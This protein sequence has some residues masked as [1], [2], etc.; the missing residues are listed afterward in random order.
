MAKAADGFC[1]ISKGLDASGGNCNIG[2]GCGKPLGYG[3]PNAPTGSSNECFFSI[4]RK[5]MR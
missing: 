1:T 2:S 4:K 3:A 5:L